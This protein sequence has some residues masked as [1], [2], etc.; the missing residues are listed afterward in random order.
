M[1][2]APRDQNNIPGKLA[3]LNTDTIQGQNLVP[4][5]VSN[6]GLLKIAQGAPLNFTM[7]P[8]D[9]RDKNYVGCWLFQGTDNL[10]YPAVADADGKILV[11]LS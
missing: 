7:R 4:I 5:S 3:C 6:T 11:D 2:D 1:A 10:C 9:P 8:I